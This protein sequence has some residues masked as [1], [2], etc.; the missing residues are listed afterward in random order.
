MK[1]AK[2]K[3]QGP[4]EAPT[5][6]AKARVRSTG[7]TVLSLP[8]LLGLGLGTFR[9]GDLRAAAEPPYGIDHRIP[10][11]TSRVVGS[12]DPPLPYTVEKTF[13]NIHWR[14]P[15]FLTPEPDTDS[16]LVVQQ[17]GEKERP[18]KILRLRDDP[19]TDQAQAFLEVSN[20]LVYSVAF[21]PGYRTNGFLYVFSNGTTSE[22]ERTNRISRFTVAR[23]APF[24]CERSSERVILEWHSQGHDGG[25]MVFGHDGMLYIST[26]DGTSDSD[27]WNTGQD[28][29]ELLGGVLRIDVDRPDGARAYSV[30]KDNPFVG[31]TNARPENWAYGLRNPW[32][33][34]IDKKTGQIWVGNN[35][36]D[37]WETAHLIRRGENYGWGGFEGSHPFYLKRRLGPP[38][39]GAPTIE[40]HHSEARSL[41]GGAVYYGDAFPELNG[42][43]VYGD[44]STGT[45][46]GARHDGA[47]VSWHKELAGTQL[48]I[49]AFAVDQRGEL[50]IV[51]HAG[52]IYRLVRSRPQRPSPKF[53]TR[54][55]ETGLFISTKEHRVQPGLIPYSVN[56][57]GWADGAVVER[58]MALPEN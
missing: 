15:I 27:G 20:R 3:T 18:S 56:A 33:M 28:L 41:T 32:R 57:P 48:Q 16:L 58:F 39:P 26:G 4:R 43:Y 42:V 46:W 55:S 31:M 13:T 47:R 35:G 7:C 37:L 22:P 44:Y 21:H 54:L 52:A 8:V 5:S 11:T 10:W 29:S 53:P 14:A 38:P 17:G 23:E 51:D 30:P 50:L 45:I 12:P 2:L 9:Q 40:H 34:C 36:Q 49:T 6:K 1:S 24:A 19:K 25:G